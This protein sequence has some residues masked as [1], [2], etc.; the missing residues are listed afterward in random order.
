MLFI[1][2]LT[3]GLCLKYTIVYSICNITPRCEYRKLPQSLWWWSSFDH[4]LYER[5]INSNRQ[6]GRGKVGSVERCEM[7]AAIN[8]TSGDYSHQLSSLAGCPNGDESEVLE[9]SIVLA[10]LFLV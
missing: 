7:L 3:H 2:A 4:R 6:W 8:S 9:A 1:T 10:F 5:T